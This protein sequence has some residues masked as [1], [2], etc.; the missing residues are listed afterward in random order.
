MTKWCLPCRRFRWRFFSA[1]RE[2]S[3]NFLRR[4]VAVQVVFHWHEATLTFA[5]TDWRV[6]Y[7]LLQC[8]CTLLWPRRISTPCTIHY[9][10]AL[11][12]TCYTNS[13]PAS[14]L[15]ASLCWS[16][17]L[18]T[19]IFHSKASNQLFGCIFINHYFWQGYSWRSE[20]L[21]TWSR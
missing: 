1:P 21:Q 11:R 5:T 8:R 4:V 18:L 14:D 2:S 15:T 19:G 12:E 9:N 3:P 16:S 10:A 7:I 6:L 13:G 20:I 17:G